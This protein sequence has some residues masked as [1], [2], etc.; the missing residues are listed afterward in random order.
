VAGDGSA[1]P[2][3]TLPR[4]SA[5][6]VS[7]TMFAEVNPGGATV[8]S[9]YNKCSYGKTRLTTANS[10]VTD[11]VRLGC[12]GTVNDVAWTFSKCDFDD[13]NSWADAANR[14]VAARGINLDQYKYK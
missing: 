14:V 10:R 13:F 12:N 2:G 3:T 8:G 9:I 1:C 5:A 4:F 7:R 6:D 11:M